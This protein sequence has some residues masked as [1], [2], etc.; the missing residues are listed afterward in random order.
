MEFH[1][2]ASI[3]PMMA[4]DEFEGL[5]ADIKATGR[6]QQVQCVRGTGHPAEDPGVGREGFVG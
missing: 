3:F 5:K 6:P 2:V 1:P 4:P